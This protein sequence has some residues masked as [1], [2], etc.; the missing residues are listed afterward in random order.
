MHHV[1]HARFV[2]LLGAYLGLVAFRH[3]YAYV[4]SCEICA[5]HWLNKTTCLATPLLIGCMAS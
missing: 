1:N 2:Y 5:G 3:L 4:L